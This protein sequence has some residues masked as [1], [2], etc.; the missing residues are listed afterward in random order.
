MDCLCLSIHHLM[1]IWVVS[2]LGLLWIMLLWSI[3]TR[4]GVFSFRNIHMTGVAGSFSNSMFNFLRNCQTVFQSSCI[5]LHSHRQ[6]MRVPI[7][8]HPH[9]HLL[10]SVIWMIASQCHFDD[11]SG[12]SL[13]FQFASPWWLMM[14]S[15]FPC[16]YWPFIYLWRNVSFAYL[17]LAYLSFYYWVVGVLCIV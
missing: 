15:I 9:Q 11:R 4:F 16:A 7:S 17:Q 13:E 8:L 3:C 14:L 1:D 2:V 12:V 10:G 6:R 5:I